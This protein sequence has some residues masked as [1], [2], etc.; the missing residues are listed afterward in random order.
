MTISRRLSALAILA[1]AL[2]T[3]GC[4]SAVAGH[5]TR[6][7]TGGRA[8]G[9]PASGAGGGAVSPGTTAS[10]PVTAPAT[11]GATTGTCSYPKSG[12]AARS[13]GVPPAKP[14][15]ATTLTLTLAVGTTGTSATVQIALTPTTT[16][17]T[18]NSIA[19]LARAKYFDRTKC[20][21]LTTQS[22]FVLQCGDPSGTGTG[23]PGYSFPD[24]LS[25]TE[26][27]PAG[28]VAMANAGPN[29]N[30]SQFFLVYR[31]TPLPPSYTVFGH[32]TAGLSTLTDVAAGGSTPAGDGT[33]TIPVVI[34]AATVE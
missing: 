7:A 27:Y 12:P 8:G 18:V 25:G 26:T 5:G 22:I 4:S 15:P 11:S 14:V 13:V 9:A 10:A 16:P 20:H 29:T 19:F 21:R 34:T 2:A 30:G 3:L 23:G 6:S 28:T 17:C 24:E 31:D 1:T 32:I 33:P